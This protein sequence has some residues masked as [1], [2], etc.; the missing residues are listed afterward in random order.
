MMLTLAAVAHSGTALWYLT[1]ATG[2]ISLILLSATVV[3]GIVASVGWTTERWPRFLSQAVHRN[4]SLFCIALIAIHIVTTVADGYVPISY[5]DAFIPFLT[6]YRPLW[7]GLGALAFDMLIA[8]G[9]TSGLRRRIGV[10]AWR[11]VHYLAYACWPIAVLHGLG[12]GS[13]ARLPIMVLTEVVCIASVVSAVAWRLVAAR[14]LP[15]S[16][17]L[18]AAS[19]T[20]ALVIGIGAFALAGPLQPGW[21]RRAGTSAAVLA[22]INARY[23]ANTVGNASGNATSPTVPSTTAPSSTSVIPT[24]PFTANVSGTIKTSAPNSAGG[25]EVLLSM[26]LQGSN[27]ALVVKLIGTP[28]NGGVSMTSSSVALGNAQGVVTALDGSTIGATVRGPRGRMDLEMQLSID[29][30][31]GSITGTVSGTSRNNQ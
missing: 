4:L 12:S 10:R 19:G 17:R 31:T 14:R 8:V 6:P 15:S 24:A 27:T 22:E 21:S 25:V 16:R 23:A 3:L 20:A 30:S 2:L 11:G 28:V 5:L 26:E 1:R 18:V 13:D 9:I 29:Q 7:I